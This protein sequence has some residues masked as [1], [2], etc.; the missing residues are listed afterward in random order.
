MR[1]LLDTHALLWF[2]EN[3]ARLSENA[4]HAIENETNEQMVS[5]VSGWE[6]AIK[7]SLGKLKLPIPYEEFFPKQIEQLGFSILPIIPRH[8]HELIKLPFHHRD[9]FDRLLIAQAKAE[10]MT[11]ITCDESMGA[12]DISLLW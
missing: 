11:M 10:D 7:D 3:E 1:L 2:L 12:Y 4:R 6:I 9:P 8:L 5:M